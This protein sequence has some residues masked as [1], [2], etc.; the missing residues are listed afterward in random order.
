MPVP[1]AVDSHPCRTSDHATIVESAP[2]SPIPVELSP[3]ASARL[4]RNHRVV[5]VVSVSQPD[6]FAPSDNTIM[7]AKKAMNVSANGR[8]MKPNP[9][10]T[11]PACMM[12]RGWNRSSS[13]PCAG[14]RIP[15]TSREPE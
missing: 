13:Q 11:M 12:E 14:L 5:T 4:R 1:V 6:R 9:K 7:T 8:A 2:A 3:S 15:A 10:N